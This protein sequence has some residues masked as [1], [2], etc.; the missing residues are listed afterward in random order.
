MEPRK[1]S[2]TPSRSV[3]LPYESSSGNEACEIYAE[4]GRTAQEWQRLL[5]TD[6]MG[7]NSDGL[8][9]HPKF[10]YAVPRRNGKNEVIAMRELWGLQNGEHILHTAHRTTTSRSAWE[11][12]CQLLEDSGTEYKSSG[13]LG[14]ET[15]R[16]R[17]GGRAQFRT[18]TTK[19]G[20]GE[21][22]D[23]LVIDEAQEYTTDQEAAL[24]YVVSDA[25]NPQTI[26]CGTPPTPDSSGTVFQAFR[27]EV[28]EG[29][30]VDAGFA[31]WSVDSQRDPTD[32]DA[33]YETNP[34]LGTILTERKIRAEIGADKLDFNIQRLGYWV[35]YNLKSAISQT[36]W[37]AA[38][39]GKLPEITGKLY[40]GVKFGHDGKNAALSIAAKTADG[41][42]FVEG[43]DCRPIRGGIDWIVSW[44]KAAD[45]AGVV[46]DGANGQASLTAMMKDARMKPPVFPKVAELIAASARFEEDL[47]GGR[48]CHMAQ[49]ALV[50]SAT[51][52]EKRA[53]GGNG[54]FGYRSIKE[55]VDVVLLE[56]VVLASWL[57][58]E[59]GGHTAKTQKV[60]Y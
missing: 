56:S 38:Y 14:Q 19:G 32:V 47:F 45:L 46:A 20:L 58:R 10:G 34:S 11:R 22:F 35:R 1:G 9:T 33:W 25:Q 52:C 12:L 15:V 21:G 27:D 40:A 16:I 55:G 17:G 3:I 30:A 43:I 6:L 54:G 48:L 36:E 18:R 2:Q 24:K 4:T 60:T 57:C 50:A 13:A 23:L 5:L 42:I 51:N 39:A 59:R 53:I 44:L 49:P 41:R 7:R 28:F 37:A 26:F 31:E 8:W 29:S